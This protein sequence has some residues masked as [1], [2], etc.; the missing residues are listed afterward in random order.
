MCTENQQFTDVMELRVHG[1][2]GTTP[3]SLLNCPDVVQVAG[4]K[5]SGF[6]RPRQLADRCDVAL[7]SDGLKPAGAG[8]E[9]EGYSWGGLTSGA[10][11]RA[12][13]LLLLPFTLA[14]VA[15]RMRPLAPDSSVSRLLVA[16]LWF[17]ARLLA[18]AMTTL[19]VLSACGVSLDV[20][21]WQCG[22]SAG[23]SCRKAS[24]GWL[25]QPLLSASPDLRLA[26]GALAPLLL[27]V[28]LW[29][30]SGRT[31]NSYES[32][33]GA[34]NGRAI[35]PPETTVNKNLAEPGLDS[36]WMWHNEYQVRR[37]RQLHL[38]T[39]FAL[40]L[41][42]VSASVPGGW[43]TTRWLLV[44]SAVYA[45]AMLLVP[46]YTGRGAGAGLR[47]VNIGVWVLLTGYAVPLAVDLIWHNPGIAMKG[48]AT[49]P[50]YDGSV[51]F[52]LTAVVAC[53]AIFALL[54]L[55]LAVLGRAQNLHPKTL[56]NCTAIVLATFSVFLAAIFSAGL[57]VFSI[58]WLTTG[59]LK[60]G[61][62]TLA[63]KITMFGIPAPIT[64]ACRS[65]PFCVAGLLLVLIVFGIIGLITR[66]FR[67]PKRFRADLDA[68]YAAELAIRSPE[69]RTR[70]K[71]IANTY[72]AARQVDTAQY[73]LAAIC[74]IGAVICGIFTWLFI[75]APSYKMRADNTFL[76]RW[77]S[78]PPETKEMCR[79]GNGLSHLSACSYLS[80]S[81]VEGTGAYLIVM[82][83]V[84]LVA[85]GMAA[86]KVLATRKQVG[87][88]WDLASFWP[89]SA[90]PFAA[91]CY[92]ERSVPDLITRVSAFADGHRRIVLAAHSQ[93]T[94]ISA[95]TLFQLKGIDELDESDVKVIPAVGFL[96]FGCVLR[97]LYA[98]YFPAYFS[99]NI[100]HSLRAD[101]LTADGPVRWRNL[102]RYSDYVGG[103]VMC[104]PPQ[105]SVPADDFGIDV[106]DTDPQWA[107]NSGDTRWPVAHMHSDFWLSPKFQEQVDELAGL[108]P[109]ANA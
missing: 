46:A 92:A 2:S 25:L 23:Q 29:K 28:L 10:P 55:T 83:L 3:E 19:V 35:T 41:W 79:Q 60:P 27:L 43:R 75:V 73:Y 90:H 78:L 72:W 6:F 39:G 31:I 88:L 1:V 109:P 12:L 80:A 30:I 53:F 58:G 105:D 26:I 96:S 24:P 76:I 49:L 44:A 93:G 36:V 87:I 8:P 108:I 100:V 16:T 21:A 85:V 56:A 89:R 107:R 47:R 71:S 20:F 97:R 81:S 102:W 74:A 18:L 38:Q 106:R 66:V 82:T 57:Y 11:S 13:W 22:R 59:S 50:D 33:S 69:T 70:E 77:Y 61:F 34:R 54:I 99:E 62:A 42:L 37:L 40:V 104:G 91:A 63:H 51:L 4:D 68:D 84:G 94:V 9:L 5:T 32:V 86:F 7:D 98:R 17:F 101:V 103:Q 95:A 52:A 64:A 65:Y 48:S 14:N 15:P 45:I 67:L